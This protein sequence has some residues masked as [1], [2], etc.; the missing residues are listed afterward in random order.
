MHINPI[1]ETLY[2]LY[3]RD[4]H[5]PTLKRQMKQHKTFTITTLVHTARITQHGATPT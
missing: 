4:Q 3:T 5:T 2:E 1:L